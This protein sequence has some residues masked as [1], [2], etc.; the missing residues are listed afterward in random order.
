M[1]FWTIRQVLFFLKGLGVE[2][3][4]TW[5]TKI[6]IRIEPN[7]VIFWSDIKLK[8]LP[9]KEGF[10]NLLNEGN[11]SARIIPLLLLNSITPLLMWKE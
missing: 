3:K 2:K 4:R 6:I 1:S 10:Q 5:S 7:E 8:N 9:K 11:Y